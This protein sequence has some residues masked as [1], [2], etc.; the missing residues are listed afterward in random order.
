[1]SRHNSVSRDRSS[2]QSDLSGLGTVIGPV[3]STNEG[4]EGS[5]ASSQETQHRITRDGSSDGVQ[6]EDNISSSKQNC[7]HDPEKHLGNKGETG[8][9]GLDETGPGTDHENQREYN[10]PPNR[11]GKDVPLSARAAAVST[12][13]PTSKI[14]LAEVWERNRKIKI[15]DSD[16][17]Q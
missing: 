8:N 6:S 9:H 2:S 4:A 15:A 11:L 3:A 10:I 7:N 1:M 17:V 12:G 16:R 14:D 13:L 5:G